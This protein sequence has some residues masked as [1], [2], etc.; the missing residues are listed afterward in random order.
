MVSA[1]AKAFL[2][3][4]HFSMVGHAALA[5]VNSSCSLRL[6]SWRVVAKRSTRSRSAATK[7]DTLSAS[8]SSS[9]VAL[10]ASTA[11]VARV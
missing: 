1:Q 9:W 8:L 3:A 6:R 5:L 7:L 2:S 4:T 11:R 10:V